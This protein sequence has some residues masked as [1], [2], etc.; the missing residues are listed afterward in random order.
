MFANDC[1]ML[2]KFATLAYYGCIN[3]ESKGMQ[4]H[5]LRAIPV[6]ESGTKLDPHTKLINPTPKFRTQEK[7]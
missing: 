6:S 2:T 5:L 3:L 7:K 1:S 4:L